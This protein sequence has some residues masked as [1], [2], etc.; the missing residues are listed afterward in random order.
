MEDALIGFWADDLNFG[1]RP[2]NLQPLDKCWAHT[3]SV[4]EVPGRPNLQ[5][6]VLFNH[7]I[8]IMAS[9]DYQD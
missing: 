2:L 6:C 4:A 8:V 3:L 9:N 1:T 5:D 7:D